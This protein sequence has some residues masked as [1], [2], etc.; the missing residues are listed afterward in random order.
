MSE[1]TD[2]D[3]ELPMQL[4]VEEGME[5]LLTGD[6]RGNA[7]VPVLPAEES[8][9]ESTG[10]GAVNGSGSDGE[11]SKV[12]EAEANSQDSEAGNGEKDAESAEDDDTSDSET[13]S[14]ESDGTSD[15]E[16]PPASAGER[17]AASEAETPADGDSNIRP[18][19]GSLV[20]LGVDIV[21]IARMEKILERT[22]HFR[23]R[24]YTQGE[25]DYCDSK[26]NPAVHYALFFAAKEAVFKALGTGFR[27]M[28][29][30]DVEVVHN[31][32]G[33][34]EV[35][36]SGEA[37]KV[38]A[39][40]GV[41]EV[42]LSLSYTHTTGVASAVAARKEDI[43]EKVKRDDEVR[44]LDQQFKNMRAMLNDIDAKLTEIE[45]AGAAHAESGDGNDSSASETP[46]IE[47]TSNITTPA[48]EGPEGPQEVV[49]NA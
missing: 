47:E 33:R 13:A 39:E 19:A 21:E 1:E 29:V 24:I 17:G 49:D 30:N 27:G 22:P 11:D 20:G 31:R 5:Y 7:E 28:G 23:E 8:E 32:F 46:M 2:S 42:Y 35:V 10:T 34:P 18:A 4:S 15:F 12:G 40:Q 41:H 3:L 45:N 38:A 36:L 25:R 37:E 26:P 43:P 48:D 9:A 6:F 16:A 14:A 44:K